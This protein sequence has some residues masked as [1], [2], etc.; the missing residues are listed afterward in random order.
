[1]IGPF[2]VNERKRIFELAEAGQLPKGF[3]QWDM[4]DLFV[5]GRV[6]AFATFTYGHGPGPEF[7]R[8]DMR[9]GQGRTMAHYAA[10]HGKLPEGFDRWLL[11]D[12]EGWNVAHEYAYRHVLPAEFPYWAVTDSRDQ[13]VAYIAAMRGNLPP[14]FHRWNIRTP[15]GATV[16]HTVA[17]MQ[18]LPVDFDQWHLEDGD[19]KT[20]REVFDKYET[21]RLGRACHGAGMKM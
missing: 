5:K 14:D 3:D 4:P 11:A 12:N 19:G 13:A 15:Q 9:D 16:A 1:M 21:Q 2:D 20:V 17:S 10:T 8:W 6:L 18:E 7:T